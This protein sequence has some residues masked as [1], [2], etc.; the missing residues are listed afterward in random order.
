MP[1]ESVT[2]AVERGIAIECK[3]NPSA[4]DIQSQ[5]LGIFTKNLAQRDKLTNRGSTWNAPDATPSAI[6]A[7][8]HSAALPLPCD[9]AMLGFQTV[10]NGLVSACL[11]AFTQA[12]ILILL[13]KML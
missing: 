12:R 3:P 1:F 9:N 2:F 11:I 6:Q 4:S 13:H 7:L 5:W 8:Y 10:S